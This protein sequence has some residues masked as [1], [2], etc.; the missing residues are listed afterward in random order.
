[1]FK[2]IRGARLGLFV[3]LGTVLLVI[4]IFVLG[5]K[6]QLFTDTISIKT[7]FTTIEGLKNGAPVWLSGYNIG[8]VKSISLANDETG[9]VEVT[10]KIKAELH[11]FIRLNS[12]ASIETEG[13]VGKKIVSITPGSSEKAIVSN[14]GFIISQTPIKISEILEDSR[15]VIKH[16]NTLSAQFA[17]ISVKINNGT[18]TV[19][20]LINDENLYSNTVE[21]LKSANSSIKGLQDWF[22]QISSFTDTLNHG[23]ANIT[24]NVNSGVL[25]LKSFVKD[26]KEGKGL[27]GHL[28]YDQATYDSVMTVVNNL[29]K[30]T[31]STKLGAER[32]AE[33][34]EALKH[35]WLFKGYFENRGYWDSANF[36][37]K[38][39][40][41]LNEL[42]KQKEI[43][44]NKLK[45]L[46]KLKNELQKLKNK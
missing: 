12:V 33:N 39:T 23:L 8:S 2:S 44:N 45:E 30:T 21:I 15:A 36:D 41:Q 20:K 6:D 1:M 28:V 16:L 18:G 22:K 37:K 27:L 34:M 25:E 7:Y 3:F 26:V 29:I 42:D 17:D 10:M 43:I 11:H 38:I 35:N 19:G 24:E 4:S 32:L 9:K 14:G 5:S 31:S 13:L 40:N 46:D